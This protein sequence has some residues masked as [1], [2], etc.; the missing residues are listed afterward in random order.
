MEEVVPRSGIAPTILTLSNR[1]K[2]SSR[3]AGSPRPF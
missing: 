3:E 1:W 2:K